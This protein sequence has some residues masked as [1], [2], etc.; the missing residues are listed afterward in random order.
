VLEDI[1]GIGEARKRE[2]LK[3]FGSVERIKKATLEQL[4]RAPKMN[5][6]S[7]QSVYRFFHPSQQ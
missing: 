1:P 4:A 5:P 3:Y 7:A 6:L 2:L